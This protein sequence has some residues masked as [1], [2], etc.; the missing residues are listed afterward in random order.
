MDEDMNMTWLEGN[1]E[2]LEL[3]I[4]ELMYDQEFFD[5]DLADTEHLLKKVLDNQKSYFDAINFEQV[6]ENTAVEEEVLMDQNYIDFLKSMFTLLIIA[7]AL[8]SLLTGGV[9]AYCCNRRF[10][11]L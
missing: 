3:G 2:E 6:T 4:Q 11:K 10:C 7:A 9:C 1:A 8:F 5:Q